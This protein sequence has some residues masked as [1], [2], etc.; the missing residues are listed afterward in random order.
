MIYASA[1]DSPSGVD[2]GERLTSLI[3]IIHFKEKSMRQW[4]CNPKFMCNNH[5]FGEHVE[6][7]MFIGTLIKK[8]SINGYIINDLLEPLSLQARHDD[9]A[10]E[11]L[12][13]KFK[14]NTPLEFEN[15]IFNYLSKDQIDHKINKLNSLVLL[16]SRCPMCQQ[17]Y[18]RNVE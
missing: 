2:I 16:L 4:M 3:F 14:H 6:H 12:K 13:R 9:L 18:Y 15:S 17:Y 1:P 7:H 5:L 11:M 8:K 10:D